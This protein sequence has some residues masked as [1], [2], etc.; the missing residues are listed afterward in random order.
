MSESMTNPQSPVGTVLI[1][2]QGEA[3]EIECTRQ[4]CAAAGVGTRIAWSMHDAVQA[5]QQQP[6][7]AV[8]LTGE[9][10]SDASAHLLR[11]LLAITPT[12]AALAVSATP[13][14]LPLP[15]IFGVITPDTA[16]ETAAGLIRAACELTITR[17]SLRA[18]R[19]RIH[20]LNNLRLRD[21][22]HGVLE[23]ELHEMLLTAQAFL[24][25]E[26]PDNALPVEGAILLRDDEGTLTVRAATTALS[27][28]LGSTLPADEYALINQTIISQISCISDTQ[29]VL[30]LRWNEQARGA[31]YFTGVSLPTADD[32]AVILLKNF[33]SSILENAILFELAA[34]DVVTGTLTRAF[35]LQRFHEALKI[36]YRQHQQL[37]VLMIDID[38]FKQ[39]NDQHGHLA[40]DLALQA[41]G[42]TLRNI[43]RDTDVV[44]RLGGDE[45]LLLLLDTPLSGGL[46]VAE[47][48][49]QAITEL[50]VKV[51]DATLTLSASIGIGGIGYDQLKSDRGFLRV[52]HEFFQQAM[53]MIMAQ[54]DGLMFRAKQGPIPHLAYAQPLVWDSLLRL[55]ELQDRRS[56]K[57]LSG[58]S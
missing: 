11:A 4:W 56:S 26:M 38:H 10:D 53:E 35:T 5:Q 25:R 33:A 32:D 52:G 37:T 58:R 3:A 51:N 18:T 16:A 43:P 13:C 45:F 46:I 24:Q 50:R 23:Q 54:T 6:A 48:I 28:Y 55:H 7:Q 15:G 17:T 1:V 44:G 8:M 9:W 57:L 20:D 49:Q 21:E 41:I 36:A 14:P 27:D 22:R 39:V 34:I 29:L 30:P 12:L 42:K 47:R 31:L 2:H 40:G 19:Q